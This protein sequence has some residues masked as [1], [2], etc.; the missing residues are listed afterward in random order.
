MLLKLIARH[1][2]PYVGWIVLVVI[3]QLASTITTLY[4][5]SLNANIIDQARKSLAA[6]E[7]EF[8]MYGHIWPVQHILTR[9]SDS[10][11]RFEDL[12]VYSIEEWFK[13]GHQPAI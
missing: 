10:E 4:L 13:D 1:S 6:E 8:S 2:K 9:S 7:C 12:R 5:P 11:E 3:L